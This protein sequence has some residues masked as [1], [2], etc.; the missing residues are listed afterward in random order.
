MSDHQGGQVVEQP[1]GHTP[2]RNN[3]SRKARGEY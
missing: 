1:H 3:Q 2:S